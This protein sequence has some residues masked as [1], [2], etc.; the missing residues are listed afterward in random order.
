MQIIEFSDFARRRQDR[1]HNAAANV[2]P[3]L[4]VTDRW[5]QLH[6]AEPERYE[7]EVHT[8]PGVQE[9]ADF[10]SDLHFR[11]AYPTHRMRHH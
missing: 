2:A 10:W 7:A 1:G 11:L 5:A 4:P 6:S 3:A 8:L 9:D